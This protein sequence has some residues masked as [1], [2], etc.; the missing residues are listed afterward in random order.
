M[1]WRVYLRGLVHVWVRIGLNAGEDCR[2]HLV[3][4]ADLRPTPIV[5][6]RFMTDL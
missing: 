3:R 6:P 4:I 2:Q 5:C 1:R